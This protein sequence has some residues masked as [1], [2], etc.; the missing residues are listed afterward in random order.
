MLYSCATGSYSCGGGGG[1]R[2]AVHYVTSEFTGQ[3]QAYGGLSDTAPG[4]PGTIY[5]EEIKSDRNN[6]YVIVD[7]G[8]PYVVNVSQIS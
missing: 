7:A 4:G 3:Y 6:K 2:I 5:V 1:G 8:A